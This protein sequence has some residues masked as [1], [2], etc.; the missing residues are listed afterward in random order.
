MFVQ[1]SSLHDLV[2]VPLSLL[3]RSQGMESKSVANLIEASSGVHFSGFHMN[4][5]Q[6]R[7][8]NVEQPTTSATNNILM[9]PFVIGKFGRESYILLHFSSSSSSSF[10]FY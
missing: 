8:S 5:L 9:Q 4:G 6:E 2:C 1:F 10:I 7:H 3:S